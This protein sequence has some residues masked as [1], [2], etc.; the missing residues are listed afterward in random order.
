MEAGLI[1]FGIKSC[2]HLSEGNSLRGK[3]CAK[4]YDQSG[5]VGEVGNRS[6]VEDLDQWGY[7]IDE[8]LQ[9]FEELG[10]H[11]PLF[12]V[13]DHVKSAPSTLSSSSR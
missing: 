5:S 1:S 13:L 11:A 8:R 4:E 9:G 3:W 2:S 10:V 6:D 12:L 7:R